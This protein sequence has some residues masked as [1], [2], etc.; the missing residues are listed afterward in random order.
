MANT[1]TEKLGLAKPAHGDVDWHIPVNE[2]WDKIDTE[3]DKALKISGTEIDA[4]KDWNGKSI[5]NLNY[6]G[7]MTHIQV[8]GFDQLLL[9]TSKPSASFSSRVCND[10][11]VKL[12]I[13]LNQKEVNLSTLPYTRF[14]SIKMNGVEVQSYSQGHKWGG[15]EPLGFYFPAIN[16][17]I[18][19]I[20]VSG[21]DI[22]TFDVWYT[23]GNGAVF[24]SSLAENGDVSLY[25][26][27]F[28]LLQPVVS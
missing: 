26:V 5:T 22:L 28:P 24:Q 27:L 21:N 14:I 7:C 13:H 8:T 25:G 23:N 9:K 19:D 4:D 3:L 10:S 20:S 18:D 12:V 1:Y 17:V 15:G 6:I 16:Y 11:H 2:N